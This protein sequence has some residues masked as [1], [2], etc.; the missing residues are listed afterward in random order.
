MRNFHSNS[1]STMWTCGWCGGGMIRYPI[2]TAILNPKPEPKWIDLLGIV[3]G[4]VRY[5]VHEPRSENI[6]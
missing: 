6:K 1:L 2:L 4:P 5:Y 3:F